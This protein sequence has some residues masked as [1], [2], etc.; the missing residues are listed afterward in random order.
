MAKQ[1]PH[2]LHRNLVR[3]VDV[4]EESNEKVVDVIIPGWNPNRVVQLPLSLI[5]EWISNFEPEI[6]TRL[7]A[8]VNSGAENPEDLYFTD[9]EVAPKP[10]E[11]NETS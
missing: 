8:N 10:E 2:E 1:I 4:S 11:I 3:V 9:F 7:I 6:G 5:C